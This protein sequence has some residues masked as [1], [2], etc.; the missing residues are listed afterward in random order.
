MAQAVQGKTTTLEF[1]ISRL[2]QEGYKVGTIKHIHED[3]FTIDTP[4]KNTYRF[5]QAGAKVVVAISPNEV[6]TIKRGPT[7]F[8]DIDQAVKLLE[9][10][11]L[12]VIFIEGLHWLIKGRA[13]LPKIVTAK[14]EAN[15]KETLEGM[16]EPILAVT[17]VISV[18]KP[19]L[20]WLK[21]PILSLESDGDK[22]VNLIKDRLNAQR[23]EKNV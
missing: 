23:A 1:L 16:V 10:E 7:Q 19:Q 21:K 13:D 5:A 12:D 14:D 22:L 11:Q 3:G 9:H 17:G 8:I 18:S 2:T 4:G 6:A 20:N 15:L